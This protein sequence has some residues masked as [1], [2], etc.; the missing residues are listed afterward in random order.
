MALQPSRA[1]VIGAL[2]AFLGLAVGLAIVLRSVELPIAL[3]WGIVAV[4]IGAGGWLTLAYWRAIDEAAKEAQKWA[5]MWGG[6]A[7]M[8]VS[9]MLL[10]GAGRGLFGL[11]AMIPAGEPP[12]ELLF[13]GA[14]VVVFGQIVGWLVA[15]ALW[16][17]R[18]R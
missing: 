3:R 4:L 17:W 7:G 1:W 11:D 6:S 13:L 18:R 5:W 15:W 10:I 2:A 16:W 14:S 12:A 8:A 9:L